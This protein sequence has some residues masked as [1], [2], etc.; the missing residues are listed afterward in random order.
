MA[1]TVGK[2]IV[3]NLSAMSAKY[4]VRVD[5]VLAAVHQLVEADA[6]RGVT[7][8]LVALDDA[9]TMSPF[10]A[11]AVTDATDPAQSKTAVDAVF[12]ALDP[13]YVM[14]LGAPDVVPHQPLSNPMFDPVGDPDEHAS[15]DLPYSCEA[16]FATDPSIFVGPTRVVGRLPDLTG[17]STPQF[18]VD[19][20]R[21]TCSWEP[22][23]KD[24]YLSYLGISAVEW[25]ESTSLSLQNLFGSSEALRLSPTEGPDWSTDLL[26]RRTHFI[27]CHGAESDSHFYGQQG[28]SY[29]VAHESSNISARLSEGT[30][31]AAECCYGAQLFDPSAV[32]GTPGLCSTYLSSGAYGFFGSST[33]AY[34]PAVGNGSADLICRYFLQ[35]VLEGASLGRA[36]L[37]ARQDFVRTSTVLDPVDLKTL[38][39]FDL[40][41]D[42]SIHPVLPDAADEPVA[43]D[44]RQKSLPPSALRLLKGRT[45]RRANLAEVGRLIGR[46][47]HVSRSRLE[48]DD[49]GSKIEEILSVAGVR[50]LPRRRL[51]SF[52]VAA[53]DEPSPKGLAPPRAST[54]HVVL[55][56]T[57]QERAPG[58]QVVALV[59]REVDG[60]IVSF[61]RLH[62]K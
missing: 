16:P 36:T 20:L 47:A 27:N 43:V 1:D 37:E 33:I 56:R 9:Q 59:A 53:L 14:I 39:Q 55:G 42:P 26:E 25:Q 61:R 50:G 35:H 10:G 29:P 45:G 28:E 57:E 32:G 4:G 7:T 19:L 8:R 48:I 15:G 23:A 5:E 13:A 3:T 41:G 24:D 44:E 60:N 31:A 58:P 12:N 38:A 22:R 2:A 46:A 11:P 62:A 54:V 51:L 52:A 30:V 49:V 17:A 6:A 40:L 34:G 18:L 21:T